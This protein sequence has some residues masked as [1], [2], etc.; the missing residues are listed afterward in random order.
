MSETIIPDTYK[1]KD[2]DIAQDWAER[3][4]ELVSFTKEEGTR[5]HTYKFHIRVKVVKDPATRACPYWIDQTVKL[6]CTHLLE[7]MVETKLATVVSDAVEKYRS[8]HADCE[9]TSELEEY[10]K[11]DFMDE[12]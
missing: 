4:V 2:S 5:K 7:L 3:G 10:M 1:G 6:S 9:F 8:K 11:S 12:L